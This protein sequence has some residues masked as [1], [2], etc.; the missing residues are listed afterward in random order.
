MKEERLIT[1]ENFF[2]RLKI[3]CSKVL[4]YPFLSGNSLKLPRKREQNT[5]GLADVSRFKVRMFP[6]YSKPLI[7]KPALVSFSLDPCAR[8]SHSL[9]S[10]LG[11]P[12]EREKAR[13]MQGNSGV[14]IICPENS[15][16]F[17]VSFRQNRLSHDF[18]NTPQHILIACAHVYLIWG[19]NIE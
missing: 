8:Y 9:P 4:A 6:V 5:F 7:P 1:C 2:R 16:N 11:L 17:F 10:S 3:T 19:V 14:L 12:F 18:R 13:A 15:L